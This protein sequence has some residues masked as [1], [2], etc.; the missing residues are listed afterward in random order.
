M[1]MIIY[2]THSG[3][4][5]YSND[6]YTGCIDTYTPAGGTKCIGKT[7]FKESQISQR[8]LLL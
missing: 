2:H 1:G 3:W 5:I 7:S 6:V 4:V 8:H